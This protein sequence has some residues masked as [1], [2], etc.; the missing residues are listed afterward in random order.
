MIPVLGLLFHLVFYNKGYYYIDH[1]IFSLHLQCFLLS[2]LIISTLIDWLLKIDLSIAAFLGLLVYGYVAALSF[3]KK[4][5]LI[6]FL[7]LC[8]AGVFHTGLIV[9]VCIFFFLMIMQTYS[10]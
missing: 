1:L 2:L 3:Y 4:T 8:L 5:K 6:T 7:K 10:V 9:V